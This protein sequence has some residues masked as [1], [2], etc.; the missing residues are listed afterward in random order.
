MA[1]KSDTAPTPCI[2]AH[3]SMKAYDPV[4]GFKPDDLADANADDFADADAGDDDDDG[5]GDGDCCGDGFF[6]ELAS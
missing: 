4:N 3:A 5:D 6:T 2:S 1:E